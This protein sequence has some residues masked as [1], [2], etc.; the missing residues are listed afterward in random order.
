MALVI[1]YCTVSDAN[2]LLTGSTVWNG[3]STTQKEQALFWGRVYLDSNYNC[4]S[5]EETDI[6][7]EIEYA[8][9]LLAEDWI[10][11]TLNR[12]ST[13]VSGRVIKKRIKAGSVESETEYL[14]GA[15]TGSAQE[16]VTQSHATLL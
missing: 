7:D 9:A 14:P 11:G 10:E 4:T 12:S 13:A 5:F 2:T 16:D 1:P 6:P 8:N 15:T 3:A